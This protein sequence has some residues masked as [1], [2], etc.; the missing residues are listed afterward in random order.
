MNWKQK[1]HVVLY[2]D[3]CI[4]CQRWN[5]L[6]SSF[7][8]FMAQCLRARRFPLP[9]LSFSAL[10]RLFSSTSRSKHWRSRMHSTMHS[11]RARSLLMQSISRSVRNAHTLLPTTIRSHSE[12]VVVCISEP[13]AYEPTEPEQPVATHIRF[14]ACILKRTTTCDCSWVVVFI[15][16]NQLKTNNEASKTC[17][18][19][20]PVK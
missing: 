2:G 9:S 7:T 13:N 6:L 10:V 17:F 3:V 12:I 11:E 16:C 19:F 1:H 15:V 8:H 5:P 18:W 4:V 20:V 14:V